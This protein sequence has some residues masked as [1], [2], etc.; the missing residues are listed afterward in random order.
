MTLPET[1]SNES[2]P[3][4]PQQTLIDEE[5]KLDVQ[6]AAKDCELLGARNCEPMMSEETRD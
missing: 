2:T 4:G 1:M 6:T 5:R 3:T